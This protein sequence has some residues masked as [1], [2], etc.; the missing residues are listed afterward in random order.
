MIVIARKVGRLAN[1][2]LLFAQFVATAAEHNTTVANLSF[3]PFF[4]YFPTTLR[5]VFC[6]FP[7]RPSVPAPAL[8]REALYRLT[9]RVAD[10][11]ALLQRRGRRVGL[12]RLRREERLDLGSETFRSALERHRVLFV[13]DWNFRSPEYCERHRAVVRAYF[14][15]LARHR[16]RSNALL[17]PAR[18]RGRFVVGVHLRRGDYARFKEGRYFYSHAQYRELME[19]TAR[20]FR[21]RDVSFLLCSDEPVP[22]E[23]FAGLDVHLGNR[24]QLEDLYALAGCDALLG[25]PSTYGRWASYWGG[26]PRYAVFDAEAAFDAS[27]FVVDTTLSYRPPATGVAAAASAPS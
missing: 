16:A 1:R 13:Q 14:E 24:H 6:R 17:E 3:T 27:S 11:L 22:L 10:L 18:D 2:L 9:L 25:P 15:P 19:R 4:R 7:A 23:P 21:D 12:I 8:P 5:D 26:V 20:A